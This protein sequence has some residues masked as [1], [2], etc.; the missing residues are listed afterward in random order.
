MRNI[1]S[2]FSVFFSKVLRGAFA[3]KALHRFF[4][5]KSVGQKCFGR[6]GPMP[7]LGSQS[8][9]AR[10]VRTDA[11]DTDKGSVEER[12]VPRNQPKMFDRFAWPWKDDSD[13]GRIV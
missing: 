4:D 11:S 3:G 5:E 12:R 13:R 10:Q 6:F 2:L 1:L 9:F 8:K 7:P